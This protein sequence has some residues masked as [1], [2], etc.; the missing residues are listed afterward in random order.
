MEN[1]QENAVVSDLYDDYAVTK[2]AVRRWLFDVGKSVEQTSRM[3]ASDRDTS[4][5]VYEF[6]IK[7]KSGNGAGVLAILKAFG[8]DGPL[9]AFHHDNSYLQALQNIGERLRN[10]AMK[11]QPDEWPAKDYEQR[12]A[13]YLAR[14]EY[15]KEKSISP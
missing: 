5:H 8:A 13:G 3:M 9:I 1:E 12:A 7:E 6:R 10:G 15:N 14:L 11:F 2:S 4:Y